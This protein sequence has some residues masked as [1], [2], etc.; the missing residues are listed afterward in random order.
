MEVMK[1]IE[2]D[3]NPNLTPAKDVY[4]KL[5]YF[6]NISFH[7]KV[8]QHYCP[9]CIKFTFNP[10]VILFFIVHSFIIKIFILF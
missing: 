4:N 6:P 3:G 8:C 9:R 1:V 7:F 5:L 10:S 2:G